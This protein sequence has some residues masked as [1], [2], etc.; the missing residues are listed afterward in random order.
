[1]RVI[2]VSLVISMVLSGCSALPSPSLSAASPAPGDHST[3]IPTQTPAQQALV[4]ARIDQN[5]IF[6]VLAGEL[7]GQTDNLTQAAQYYF[8]AAK[9]SD[10]IPLLTR[11]TQI[12]L[13]AKRFDL[14]AH[15]ARRW[16]KQDP[17]SV[18]AAATLTI[19]E[20]Q[21]G[22]LEAAD[23]ALSQWLHTESLDK[24]TVLNELGRY[25]EANVPR[26]AATAYT[27]H[28]AARYPNQV[29]AQI[30]VAKLNL[31]FGRYESAVEAAKHAV[32]LAPNNKMAHDVLIVSLGQVKDA[33]GMLS[34][35]KT[36]HRKFPTTERYL[37]GLIEAEINVGHNQ[38]AGLLIQSALAKRPKDP[39]QL[40]GLALLALQI[41]RPTLAK[42]ALQALEK[43]PK[44]RSLARLLL[45][46]LAAQSNQLNTAIKYFSKIPATSEHYA[47]A[48]ILLSATFAETDDLSAALQSLDI[49][50]SQPIDIA[51][52]QRLTLAKAGLLVSQGLDQEA[53]T[54][55]TDALTLW[56][57]ASDIQLQRAML[58]IKLNHSDKAEADLR[59]IIENDPQNAPALNALGYTLADENR[60]LGEA[61]ALIQRALKIDP[62]NAAYLDS[63]GWAQ[64]RLGKLADAQKSLEQSFQIVPDAEVGAHLGIVLW[65][66]PDT[67]AA[68][69]VW[70][71]AL[72]LNPEQPELLKAVQQ[73][74]PDL[75]PPA[76][77]QP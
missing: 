75:L 49:A 68:R 65:H 29:D 66:K 14:S 61:Y 6:L 71:R 50:L 31:K 10:D 8:D 38:Q 26:Q 48:R 43:Q 2:P 39:D 19:S 33:Q 24:Q 77:Q 37:N 72:D 47:E 45:G 22:H 35:L 12:E 5:P 23:Q 46:R 42:K 13:A 53:L 67:T 30:V 16:V 32:K 59:H 74:A 7:A 20:I 54:T 18:K 76:P 51:D 3:V 27:D 60:D 34:A 9:N 56:P 69:A 11:A 41:E 28:L 40:R 55:L 25:L 21:L 36:A 1:M 4:T 63:L 15:T 57:D 44:Q 58:L 64:Y 70:K 62:N 73:Y 52:K 17:K